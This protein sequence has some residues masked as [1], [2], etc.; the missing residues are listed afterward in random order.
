MKYQARFH[1]RELGA[2]G[3]FYTIETVVEGETLEQATLNLYE[4]FECYYSPWL[5]PL[6]ETEKP[7]A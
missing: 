3:K 5:K 2:I 7:E 1:G 6:E 4:K